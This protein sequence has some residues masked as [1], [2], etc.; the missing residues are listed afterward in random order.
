M[1]IKYFNLG[2]NL[3]TEINIY[4]LYGSNIGLI[5]D[6]INKILKPKFSSN[7]FN[8]DENEILNNID[9]FKEGILSKSFFDNEKLIIIN[10]ATDKILKIIEEINEKKLS[11]LKIILKSGVLEKKS[12]LRSFFEKENKL[13]IIPFYED[14]Y[15]SLFSL[16]T[17]FLKEKKIKL[18]TQNINLIIERSRGNRLSLK[19]ELEK[20]YN[21]SITKQ[22]VNYNE[23]LKLSNLS[24]NFNISEL[25]DECLAQNKKKTLNILNENNSSNEDDIIIIKNFLFKLKRLKRLKEKLNENNNSDIVIT[26]YRP[27]IFWKDKEIIKKQL[28]SLSLEKLNKLLQE[29]TNIESLI[30]KNSQS[31]KIILNNFIL[32]NL[33]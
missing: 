6:T 7:I 8:Y 15:Q 22:V 2:K 3:N 4:L 19:N 18:S 20:I 25:V 30:K 27:P 1:I 29:I 24:E 9:D 26:E 32:E 28:Q 12:K 13:V 31:S 17:N 21:L 10:R 5:E 11:D 33:K 23:I 16:T 14:N